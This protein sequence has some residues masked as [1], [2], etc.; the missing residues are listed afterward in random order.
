MLEPRLVHYR[1]TRRLST[2][3]KRGGRSTLSRSLWCA[4]FLWGSTAGTAGSVLLTRGFDDR[5]S[6]EK[7]LEDVQKR[8]QSADVKGVCLPDTID[9][10]DPRR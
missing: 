4:C 5:L 9:P 1:A 7:Y 8:G 3:V 10:R 2:E 6:R